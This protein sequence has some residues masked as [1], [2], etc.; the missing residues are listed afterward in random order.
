MSLH[1]TAGGAGLSLLPAPL[2]EITLWWC[3]LDLRKEGIAHFVGWL[4]QSERARADRFGPPQLRDRF[5]AGRTALRFILSSMLG[6][7]PQ[8]VPLRRGP[9]G[10]PEIEG[11]D[12]FDFNVSHTADSA[13][14]GVIARTH[15]S[16]RIGVDIERLDRTVNADRLS[17]KF[18]TE[19][20]GRS[21]LALP[22]DDRIR[23]FL[24]YWTY[25]EAMSK[26][27]GDG[28]IAP[29]GK[30]D[31]EI[32]DSPRLAAGPPPYEPGAWTLFRIAAPAGFLAAL[33]VW[34]PGDDTLQPL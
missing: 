22:A 12:R 4:S 31:V 32:G 6:V 8:D 7:G 9:R 29:F 30:L 3:D 18:L 16:R 27:T 34:A 1:A 11:D 21:L 17:S 14:I 23:S 20:E 25:K 19:N 33:A 2:P 15:G 28:L 24:R 26:A 10:R 13:L 5:I